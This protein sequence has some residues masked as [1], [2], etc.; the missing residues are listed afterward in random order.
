[1]AAEAD[2]ESLS[3]GYG[4]QERISSPRMTVAR[5]LRRTT[6]VIWHGSVG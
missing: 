3:G 1:M 5:S 2:G 4:E 6:L